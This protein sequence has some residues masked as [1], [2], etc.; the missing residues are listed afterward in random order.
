MYVI[1]CTQSYAFV[2][3]ESFGVQSRIQMG[4]QR[5]QGVATPSFPMGV[6]QQFHIISL[7][8]RKLVML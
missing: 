4:V 3:S 1:F 6:V 5:D 2:Y 7:E 8:K